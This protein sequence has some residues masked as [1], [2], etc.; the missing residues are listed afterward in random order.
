MKVKWTPFAM[1]EMLKIAK[2]ICE[3]FGKVA[4]DKF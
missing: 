1:E 2:Y 4:K 3:N